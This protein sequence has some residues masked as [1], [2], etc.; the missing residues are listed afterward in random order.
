MILSILTRAI[1][2]VSAALERRRAIHH[3][4]G[5]NDQLLRDIG[6]ERHEIASAVEDR[7]IRADPERFLARTQA[8]RTGSVRLRTGSAPRSCEYRRT[9]R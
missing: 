3:L 8:S 4:S 2:G 7:L 9:A 1:A 5:L 6:I